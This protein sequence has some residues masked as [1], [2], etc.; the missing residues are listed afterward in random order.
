MSWL[1]DRLRERVASLKTAGLPVRA[2]PPV[3]KRTWLFPWALQKR[4]ERKI[5]EIMRRF[6]ATVDWSK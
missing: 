6:F 3:R 5:G 1:L 2:K 4:Y